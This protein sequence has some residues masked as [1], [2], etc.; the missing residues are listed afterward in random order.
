M[1]TG[2]IGE[3]SVFDFVAGGADIFALG[4]TGSDLAAEYSDVGAV[5]ELK[6]G[7]VGVLDGSGSDLALGATGSDLGATAEFEAGFVGEVTD[8]DF[9]AGGTDIFL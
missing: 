5:A 2:F 1:K 4:A 7:F 3:G 9:I 6:A 8:L